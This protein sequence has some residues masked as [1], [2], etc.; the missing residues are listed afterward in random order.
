MIHYVVNENKK[1]V[2]AILDNSQRGIY[3]DIT[4]TNDAINKVKKLGIFPLDYK[5]R[6]ILRMAPKY[7]AK[8]TCVEPDVFDVEKGKE[9]AK[10]KV[11]DKYYNALDKRIGKFYDMR[12]NELE[13]LYKY[14]FE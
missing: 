14:I 10:K 3:N 1:T 11:L 12:A 2:V 5:E 9:I 13:T 6:E 4:C 8:T 7:T